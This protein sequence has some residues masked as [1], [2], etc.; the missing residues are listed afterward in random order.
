VILSKTFAAVLIRRI[1]VGSGSRP[2]GMAANGC[3]AHRYIQQGLFLCASSLAFTFEKTLIRSLR[4]V[5][6]KKTGCSDLTSRTRSPHWAPCRIGQDEHHR[7][8]AIS[9]ARWICSFA[10]H[11]RRDSRKGT[12]RHGQ[13]PLASVCATLSYFAVTLPTQIFEVFL[14]RRIRAAKVLNQ[15]RLRIFARM[16]QSQGADD[17]LC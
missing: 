13:T 9:G 6:K 1:Q 4:D 8:T 16:L 3:L 10:T 14:L 7:S 12:L 11:Q 17:A 5:G 2:S 15:T